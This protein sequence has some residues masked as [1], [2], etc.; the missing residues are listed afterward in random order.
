M[1]ETLRGSGSEASRGRPSPGKLAPPLRSCEN[2]T[3]D[4]SSPAKAEANHVERNL[5]RPDG[6]GPAILQR[7][8]RPGMALGVRAFGR[9]GEPRQCSR[10]GQPRAP[11]LFGPEGHGALP[12]RLGL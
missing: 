1:A 4:S 8:T 2:R 11:R 7:A 10:P 12:Q 6:P 9:W 5:I 3:F